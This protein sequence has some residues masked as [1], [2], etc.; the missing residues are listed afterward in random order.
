MR[1]L[2]AAPSIDRCLR[3]L[4]HGIAPTNLSLSSVLSMNAAVSG[5]VVLASRLSTD[6]SLFAFVLCSIVVFAFFPL[7]RRLIQVRSSHNDAL[8]SS[9][10]LTVS[11]YSSG[12]IDI[13]L[14]RFDIFIGCLCSCACQIYL[15]YFHIPL[16]LHI[17]HRYIC[18]TCHFDMGAKIQKVSWDSDHPAHCS[19]GPP[20]LF[21]EIRG[22]WDVAIPIVN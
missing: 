1:N 22:P 7:L 3:S 17:D 10:P 6:M 18:G 11:P 2:G 5:S 13:C 8:L 4:V 16:L 14:G 9:T 12:H 15:G 20:S 21:S 19:I